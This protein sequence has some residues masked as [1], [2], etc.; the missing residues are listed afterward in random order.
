MQPM[1]ASHALPCIHRTREETTKLLLQPLHGALTATLARLR[2]GTPWTALHGTAAEQPLL[3]GM[4]RAR[5]LLDALLL[6]R[7]FT[8][9]TPRS[10]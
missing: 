9:V 7:L 8:P 6:V 2:S 10:S 4:A 5:A 3:H 1:H